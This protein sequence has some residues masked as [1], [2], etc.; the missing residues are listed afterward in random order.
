[1]LMDIAWWQLI[2]GFLTVHFVA[3]FS[4]AGV[5]QL[6]HVMEDLD[7]PVPTEGSV[8]NQWAVHQMNTT[9][10]FGGKNKILSWFVGGLNY[11][12]EHHLFPNISHVHY[13]KI[14]PIVERT[15]REFNIPYHNVPSFR[16]AL[17]QHTR[18][19]YKLGH[20]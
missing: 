12:V 18:M 2:I 8:L 3:G 20:A 9:L 14:A 6:A 7:Y 1:M 11:Q 4:L 5:F 17:S 10:N 15:A 13:S 16:S 19:L